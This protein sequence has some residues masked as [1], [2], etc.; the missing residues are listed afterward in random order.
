ML[1]NAL[2]NNVQVERLKG[3]RIIMYG[4]STRN[5]N[6]I[7]ELGIKD[8][9]LFFVD[10]NEEKAGGVLGE[11]EIY[12]PAVLQEYTGCII[13]SVLV[14]CFEEVMMILGDNGIKAQNCLFYY[15]EFFNIEEV[16]LSNMETIEKKQNYKYIHIFSN[17]KFVIPFYLMLE[18]R[19]SIE[20]HLFIVAYRITTD[21]AGILHFLMEKCK[22]YHNILILDDAHGIFNKDIHNSARLIPKNLD[23]NQVFYSE[24]LKEVCFNAYKIFF[25][26]AIWG[27]ETKKF[28]STLTRYCS[29]KIIW[30]CFGGDAYFDKNSFEVTQI[31]SKIRFCPGSNGIYEVVK[32]NYG[33]CRKIDGEAYYV[34]IPQYMIKQV[35]IHDSVNILLGHSAAKYGNHM[36]GL[37]I[38][39]KYADEDIKIYCPL[40]YG[41]ESYRR[42]V[43]R[44]GEA[45]FGN[46][47]IPLLSYMEQAQYFEFLQ[48]IDVAVFPLKR[49][50]AESTFLL[51]KAFH[52]KI[53]AD[54]GV[55]KHISDR[56]LHIEDISKIQSETLEEFIASIKQE[57][58]GISDLNNYVVDEW[59][60]I[61]EVE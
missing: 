40:S 27:N 43:I 54:M 2:G 56:F 28:V 22:K 42:E 1:I 52:V 6:A 10:S 14:R 25:H 29:Q 44:K 59:T 39:K 37:E 20:E 17:D 47:F 50:A 8:N 5:Q 9:V 38:L 34:Y 46:K 49:L 23:C 12:S 3:K 51:L 32:Q 36:E 21:F 55:V 61:L 58:Y 45:M 19:F 31:L 33:I 18:K 16:F 7:E 41:S 26:S 13:L 11:Y 4:A 57:P 53:Y 30:I 60:R 15:P 24:T 48:S 35:P